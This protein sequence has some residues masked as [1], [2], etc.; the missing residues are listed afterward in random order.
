MKDKYYIR[1]RYASII[2]FALAFVLGYFYGGDKMLVIQRFS[3][4]WIPNVISVIGL[5]LLFLGFLNSDIGFFKL[6]LVMSIFAVVFYSAFILTHNRTR[7][8]KLSSTL[9]DIVV[10]RTIDT[11][12]TSFLFY[13]RINWFEYEMF[14]EVPDPNTYETELSIVDN[15]ILLHKCDANYCFDEYIDIE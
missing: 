14:A 6:G 3:R 9:Y 10:E 4:F 1:M 2:C 8:Q 7:Y 11:D 12:N 15:Q 5:L 13:Q